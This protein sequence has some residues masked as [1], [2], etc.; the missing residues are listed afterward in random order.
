M[1]LDFWLTILWQR[2]GFPDVRYIQIPWMMANKDIPTSQD[3]S[4]FRSAYKLPP[5]GP[6]QK[7]PLAGLLNTGG[8]ASKG[9]NHYC[10]VIWMPE[11]EVVHVLG[12]KYISTG[13]N[14]DA[15]DW[16]EWGGPIIWRNL[17]FLHG[18]GHIKLTVRSLDWVQ[19]EYDCGPTA[20]QVLESI[21]NSGLV[22]NSRGI[23]RKPSLPCCHPIR[24]RIANDVHAQIMEIYGD[25][26]NQLDGVL[27]EVIQELNDHPA[28]RL[29]RT[30][31]NLERSMNKCPPCISMR[32][33]TLRSPS[34]KP[35]MPSFL[36]QN[37][38]KAKGIPVD[39]V[40]PNGEDSDSGESSSSRLSSD[41]TPAGANKNIH[42]ADWSQARLGRFPRPPGP[43]LPPLKSLRG[44][45]SKFDNNFDEYD[46]GPT[47]DDLEATA[48]P[49]ITLASCDLVYMAH[50]IINNPWTMFKDRGYRIL[51]SYADLFHRKDPIMI[52][53]HISPVGISHPSSPNDSDE[54]IDAHDVHVLG[55]EEMLQAA[56]TYD[57]DLMF[58]TGRT[59][60][61][62]YIRLDLQ[63]DAITP[64]NIQHSYD[65]DSLIWVSV[66]PRFDH[67]VN[68][69][70]MPH[71]RKKAPIWKHNH[72]YV[73]LLIPQSDNDRLSQG[74]RSEWWTKR[75][76][77]SQ[78]PHVSFGHLSEGSGSLNL[79]LC[80]PRMAH[81]QP[82]G[83]RWVTLVPPQLQEF[84]WEKVLTPAMKDVTTELDHPY[85]GLTKEN[86][87][88]KMGTWG[89]RRKNREGRRAPT[90][91]FQPE[92]FEKLIGRMMEIVGLTFQPL[93]MI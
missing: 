44:L 79:Y 70:T 38:S 32:P 20:C 40:E 72:V 22:L 11:Q 31:S 54:D 76:R 71:I 49:T 12:R 15:K 35:D 25:H 83:S 16:E 50:Q 47:L 43:V 52:L 78:I 90:F 45:W 5:E 82:H 87:V 61:H 2:L 4:D 14:T 18:W 64:Q 10:C 19:N 59:L 7:V 1:L 34:A 77:L 85:V 68:V 69:F 23:W 55:A 86:L 63:R 21:W 67:A 17:A 48:P 39:G 74:Q 29:L 8:D 93:L 9:G 28:N 91:P 65:I 92:T 58:L 66:E 62:Q 41:I 33:K 56:D 46:E 6:C 13:S 3:V 51:P 84:F 27:D 26:T 80:L 81:K 36:N 57:D 24:L 42:V 89:R 37:I 73:D 60:E 75:F 88:L 30:I 53:E